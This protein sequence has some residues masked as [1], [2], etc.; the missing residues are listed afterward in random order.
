LVW[1]G[2]VWFGLVWFGL[3]WFGFTEFRQKYQNQA[4]DHYEE[5]K[6]S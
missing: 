2:L 1:F 4:L 3:V 5:A 6:D